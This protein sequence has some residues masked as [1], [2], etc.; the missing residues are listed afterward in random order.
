MSGPHT[1]DPKTVRSGVAKLLFWMGPA[2]AAV[3]VLLGIL[4]VVG[5]LTSGDTGLALGGLVFALVFCCAGGLMH[6]AGRRQWVRLYPDAIVWRTVFSGPTRVPWHVVHHVELP[7]NAHQGRTVVL[8]LF[9]G[10]R[11]PVSAITMSSGSSGTTT[12]WADSG[13]WNAGVD[14]INA[15]KEWLALR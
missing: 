14:I 3:G 4:F 12:Y 5:G 6:L 7:A 8:V 13:Y 2:I 9:D 15:H 11:V 1:Q 10:R